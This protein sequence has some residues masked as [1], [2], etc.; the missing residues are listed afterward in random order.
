M[1]SLDRCASPTTYNSPSRT[2]PSPPA[3]PPRRLFET[4]RGH[5]A[6]RLRLTRDWNLSAVYPT[7]PAGGSSIAHVGADVHVIAANGSVFHVV[8]PKATK[9][10]AAGDRLGC[11]RIVAQHRAFVHR[12]H[13]DVEGP[14][15]AG[16]EPRAGRVP[17]QLDR[18]ELGRRSRRRRVLGSRYLGAIPTGLHT[19]DSFLR[20]WY[21]VGDQPSSPP[22]CAP[23]WA[24]RS[25]A[26]SPSPPPPAPPPPTPRPSP[27]SP[28]PRSASPAACSSSGPPRRSRPA[29][30]PPSA[31]TPSASPPPPAPPSPTPRP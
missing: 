4:Q 6:V 26:P 28:A 24:R 17:A 31:T 27:T 7:P 8:T 15:C 11:V 30:S 3:V 12:V 2:P 25:T 20:R 23:P 21:L 19:Y 14:C 22:P 29:E 9:V 5:L 1:S 16:D 10:K 18:A 13:D